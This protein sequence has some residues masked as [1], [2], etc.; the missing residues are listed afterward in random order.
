MS[1]AQTA[2]RKTQELLDE[3]GRTLFFNYIKNTLDN[4][5]HVDVLI[6]TETKTAIEVLHDDDIHANPHVRCGLQEIIPGCCN[7]VSIWTNG[8]KVS[9]LPV[10]QARNELKEQVKGQRKSPSELQSHTPPT[11][12]FISN[13]SNVHIATDSAMRRWTRTM[14]RWR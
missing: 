13:V 2:S 7:L 9:M 10:A 8:K 5:S 14:R 1:E 6:D 4:R 3:G 12:G 11:S